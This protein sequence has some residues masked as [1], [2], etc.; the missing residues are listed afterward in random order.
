MGKINV[1]R[2]IIGGVVAAVILFIVDFVL[3]GMILEGDLRRMTAL[4]K[5]AMAPERRP[6]HHD[7]P[8]S[9]CW[10]A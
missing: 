10:S 7:P 5:P 3:N 1:G 4:G 8:S 9:T 6:A 2:W